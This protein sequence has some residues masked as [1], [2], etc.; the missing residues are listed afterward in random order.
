[1]PNIDGTASDSRITKLLIQASEI[2]IAYICRDQSGG[3]SSG[4]N[5]GSFLNSLSPAVWR[6]EV[7]E[8][9]VG[10]VRFLFFSLHQGCEIY[11]WCDKGIRQGRLGLSDN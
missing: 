9:G 7:K 10:K 6:E 3:V 11:R 5:H 4:G 8:K 1:M 2:E